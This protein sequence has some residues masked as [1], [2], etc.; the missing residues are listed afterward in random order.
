LYYAHRFWSL[1]HER[2]NEFQRLYNELNGRYRTNFGHYHQF[3]TEQP[4][5]S[6]RDGY[7]FVFERW[8]T[9]SKSLG[10]ETPETWDH[11]S[12]RSAG[13]ADVDS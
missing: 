10:L 1:L 12:T 5:A 4:T 6:D 7:R 11:L 13:T 8:V 2:E 9:I 3:V